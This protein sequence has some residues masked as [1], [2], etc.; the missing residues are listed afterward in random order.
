MMDRIN[1]FK[2]IRERYDEIFQDK[3]KDGEVP[4][5]STDYGFFGTASI[6]NIFEFFQKI[7]LEKYDKF[8]D[9]GSGDGRVVLLASLFTEAEGV[10][11]DEKLVKKSEEIRDELG[12]QAEFHCKDFMNH[13]FSDYDLIFI[14]P[15]KAFFRSLEEKIA[16]EVEGEVFVY[17]Q[18]YQPRK[19]K[20]G[21]TV[22]VNQMPIIKYEPEI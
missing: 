18:V 15:D 20:K 19:L 17:N 10:E 4:M 11:G 16:R 2:R 6:F 8:I 5:R 12:L 14:Y 21:K 13:N 22:W 9:L 7:N 1:H 3:V